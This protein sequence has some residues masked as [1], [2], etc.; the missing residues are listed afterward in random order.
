MDHAE[1]QYLLGLEEG[2]LMLSGPAEPRGFSLIELMVTLTVLAFALMMGLPSLSAWLQNSKLR[3]AAESI[4]S[5]LQLA[6]SEAVSRNAL[7]RF[8]LT[9]SLDN[10]CVLSPTSANWVVN[11]GST[12]AAGNCGVAPS[13]T[14][15]PLIVQKRDA[16]KD[17]AGMVV[18]SGASSISFNGLGR[19]TPAAALSIDLSNPSL[20]DCAASGGPVVCLRVVVSAA[21]QVRM[22]N[23]NFSSTDPQGC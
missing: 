21:G 19:P 15:A 6:R 11:T 3:S 9:S 22:C 12:D 20:G 8:Q 17:L 13:D 23:P 18:N 7:V 1:P 4:M 5:G 14:V 10:S 16:T 2:R